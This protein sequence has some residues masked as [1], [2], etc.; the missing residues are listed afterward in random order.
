MVP[1]GHRQV[2]WC[3]GGVRVVYVVRGAQGEVYL[4]T[5]YAK[6]KS[7]SISLAVLKEIRRVLKV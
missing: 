1:F 5:R 7:E 4:L 3:A 2:W 6:S